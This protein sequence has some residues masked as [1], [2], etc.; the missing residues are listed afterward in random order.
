MNFS[1]N[2]KNYLISNMNI[3]RAI[4]LLE[5]NIYLS[6]NEMKE[7]KILGCGTSCS[8]VR[9]LAWDNL[10]F[11]DHIITMKNGYKFHLSCH[12]G[13]DLYDKILPV[14]QPERLNQTQEQRNK[15]FLN[16]IKEFFK[17]EE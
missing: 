14:F 9:G 11:A 6:C 2:L 7:Y 15:K 17:I 1:K 16:K 8:C 12:L 5:E 4:E 13:N 10:K 3:K